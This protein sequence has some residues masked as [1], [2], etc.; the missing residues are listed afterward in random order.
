MVLE[1]YYFA[2]IVCVRLG[3]VCICFHNYNIEFR[4]HI[5]IANELFYYII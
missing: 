5:E 1:F 4:A 2:D 3:R